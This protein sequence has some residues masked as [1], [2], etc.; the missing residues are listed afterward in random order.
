MRGFSTSEGETGPQVEKVKPNEQPKGQ[1]EEQSPH[2]KTY[3]DE[4]RKNI[5]NSSL[6]FVQTSGWS[7]SSLSS[8]AEALGYQGVTH[9]MFPRGGIELV[10][11]FYRV[12]N[13]QL[14]ETLKQKALEGEQD[15]SKK[16]SDVDFICFAL[17]ER[18]KMITPYIDKWPEALA[19]MTMPPNVPT[20]LANLLTLVDDICYYAGDRSV[21]MNWYGKRISIAGVYKATELYMLQDKSHEYNQTW[22][23]LRRR[24]DELSQLKSFISQSE[25]A[26]QVAQSI[27]IAT[28]T[29]ARNILGLNWKR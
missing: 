26:S 8:G 19:L 18:L 21:D 24:M 27:A 11:F 3:E 16:V 15:K 10:E 22:D 2:Y 23:F 12:S 29:T 4:I 28:F 20:S 5:L 14:A 7:K 17:E 9:G 6:M 13:D 1:K 25:Q